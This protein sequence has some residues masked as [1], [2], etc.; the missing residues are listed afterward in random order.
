[1][2]KQLTDPAFAES[3]LAHALADTDF[4]KQVA[5]T[6]EPDHFTNELQQRLLRVVKTF[7]EQEHTAPAGLILGV[8][9]TWKT[10][11]QL[12]EKL[13]GQLMVYAS[14]LLQKPLQNRR[15]LLDRYDAFLRLRSLA[16]MTQRLIESAKREDLDNAEKLIFEYV[17]KRQTTRLKKERDGGLFE[18]DP[19]TRVVRRIMQGQDKLY[20]LISPLDR[21]N[22][23]L[24]VGHLGIIVSQFSGA[25]KSIALAH[26]VTRAVLQGKPVLYFVIGEM[27]KAEVE[28]R[29]D[30]M[31][32]GLRRADLDVGDRLLKRL[33]NL[34]RFGLPPWIECLPGDKH[35]VQDL[36]EIAYEIE[37]TSNFKADTVV[38]D[39]MDN[40][41]ADKARADKDDYGEE[42]SKDLKRWAQDDSIRVWTATQGAKQAQDVTIVGQRHMGGSKSKYEQADLLMSINR[43][44]E[45]VKENRTTIHIPK[46][47]HDGAGMF[48][49]TI[50]S[51]YSRLQFFVGEWREEDEVGP[52]KPDQ[53]KKAGKK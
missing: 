33:R 38:V 4:L 27:T 12:P 43:T 23:G 46:D 16:S 22:V 45:E 17:R 9:D 44:P 50:K 32:S 5:S 28:D 11:G 14:E 7:Y 18:I 49:T 21:M 15:Y 35:T 8:L 47:R 26:M 42:V 34:F 52:P 31:I 3:F 41:K 1:M 29:L 2:A 19:S 40:V 20:T 39:Y 53:P 36:R 25:G 30:Q 37:N 48:T 51:D 10:K 24:G 6:L 13:A